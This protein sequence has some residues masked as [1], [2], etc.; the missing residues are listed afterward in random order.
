MVAVLVSIATG[1]RWLVEVSTVPV[2]APAFW[3][4]PPPLP[5]TVGSRRTYRR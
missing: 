4:P 3:G 2:S 1:T 5:F